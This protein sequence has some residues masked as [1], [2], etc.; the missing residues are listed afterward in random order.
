[1]KITGT[2]VYKLGVKASLPGR[3][4]AYDGRGRQRVQTTMEKEPPRLRRVARGTEA[5][6]PARE[7]ALTWRDHTWE[8]AVTA[9]SWIVAIGALGF[10]VVYVAFDAVKTAKTDKAR[11][12]AR[13]KERS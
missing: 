11:R 13:R 8:F 5:P 3:D 9:V 4:R 12:K 10:V 7:G 6:L 1:M 2:D